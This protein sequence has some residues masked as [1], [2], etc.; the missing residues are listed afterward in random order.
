MNYYSTKKSLKRKKSINRKKSVKRKKSINRKKSV[1]R[2]KSVSKKKSV[3]RKKSV[4][5]KKIMD[6]MKRKKE[7]EEEEEVLRYSKKS[8]TEEDWSDICDK[9]G[10][11]TMSNYILEDEIEK[12]TIDLLNSKT[13]VKDTNI[14]KDQFRN[15]FILFKSYFSEETEDEIKSDGEKKLNDFLTDFYK[16]RNND[17]NKNKYALLL[18]QLIEDK[19]KNRL[20]I[21]FIFEL[22]LEPIFD[23]YEKKNIYILDDDNTFFIFSIL[24]L[25]FKKNKDECEY[26]EK[27]GD[28]FSS[29]LSNV[30]DPKTKET[31]DTFELYFYYHYKQKESGS[32]D[33]YKEIFKCFDPNLK[34]SIIE[35]C[36]DLDLALTLIN[37]II[38][39]PDYINNVNSK[40]IKNILKLLLIKCA[41]IYMDADKILDDKLK[42]KR[43]ED[44]MQVVIRLYKYFKDSG[45]DVTSII[46]TVSA[47]HEY[48]DFGEAFIIEKK[49]EL[50]YL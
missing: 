48:H 6:G 2:K 49:K 50:E 33:F 41:S 38:N 26:K 4:S 18:K 20:P 37:Q 40:K 46:E 14:T 11:I 32:G 43:K 36:T 1:K 9:I 44:V 15:I 45:D 29:T 21:E 19:I 30:Y 23:Y 35:D 24:D 3:K 34:R 10:G 16:E 27:F 47:D 12:D 22:F 17:I 42:R 31:H 7:E 5:R 13:K 39:D 28:D 25:F 8:K